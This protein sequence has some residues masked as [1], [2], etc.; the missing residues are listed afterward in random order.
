M[1]KNYKNIELDPKYTPKKTEK[2]MCP[3]QKA[4]F[5]NLL[6][7][8][9]AKLV[10]EQEDLLNDIYVAE[11]NQSSET[12]DEVDKSNLEQDLASKRETY[13]RGKNLLMQIDAALVRLE[14]GTFGFSVISGEEIGLKRMMVRTLATMTTEEREEY[15]KTKF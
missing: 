4:Y 8:D 15:E 12:G 6:N 5:Y 3:E 13:R 11:K 1:A 10:S 2:Y 14:N 9:R 7:Q